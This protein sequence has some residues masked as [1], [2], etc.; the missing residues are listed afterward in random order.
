MTPGP[1]WS[2]LRRSGTTW[3]SRAGTSRRSR[4]QWSPLRRSGTTSA[5]RLFLVTT[6]RPQWSPLRRSGTTLPVGCAG[7]QPC[8]R[9]NGA[10]SGGAG[11]PG[12]STDMS[13]SSSSRNGARSGGAGRRTSSGGSTKP[14]SLPQWSP[15]RRSGTTR[16]PLSGDSVQAAAPQWSPLRR[17][18]T[19]RHLPAAANPGRPRRNGA[20]S[21]GA[22]RPSLSR[23]RNRARTRPQWSPLRRSG[24][25]CPAISGQ[26]LD[27]GEPQWSPLR[28][29]GTTDSFTW[30]G[31]AA[32]TA[33]M[34]PA[35][36]ERDDVVRHRAGSVVIAVAAMEP[37]PEERDDV[38]SGIA[39]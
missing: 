37:A 16:T 4:P 28:R 32:R 13:G 27:A 29:S 6:D 12:R 36:E 21:G 30:T 19:T 18:G 24:T 5:H 11:R 23:Y 38:R 9:R 2:P 31:G 33:A 14:S 10:R 1:Q 8:S 35:P 15:L 39:S 7:I 22:G 20:R 25:T 26:Q 34:E 3:E 17:S